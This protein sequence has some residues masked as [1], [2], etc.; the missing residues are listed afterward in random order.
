M[1][2][3]YAGDWILL[4]NA[5]S[6]CWFSSISHQHLA[7]SINIVPI[8][9]VMGWIQVMSSFLEVYH[10]NTRMRNEQSQCLV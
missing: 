8:L 1:D 3:L 5:R 10:N 7:H 6:P 2:F 4:E 9:Q